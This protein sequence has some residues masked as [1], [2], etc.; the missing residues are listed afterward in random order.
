[1]KSFASTI[2]LRRATLAD[3]AHRAGVTVEEEAGR[4]FATSPLDHV[5]HYVTLVSCDCSTFIQDGACLHHSALLARL[6]QLPTDPP[7]A[8]A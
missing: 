4:W 6:D 3:S 1:M 8:A 5:R 7:I 2:D